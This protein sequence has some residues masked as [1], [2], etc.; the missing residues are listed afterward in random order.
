ML[1]H[2][3]NPAIIAHRGAS[4][5]APENTLAAFELAVR[6]KADA[7]ELDAKL[8]I[9][10]Y[11]VVFHDQTLDRTTG[12]QGRVIDSKLAELRRL[13]AGSHF[14]VAYKGEQIPTLDEVFDL[15]GKRIFINVELTNYA[16][17]LDRLPE[18]VAEI[19]NKH[20]L[21]ERVMFSSFN[22]IALIRVRRILP[23]VPIGL[24]ARPGRQG[25]WARSWIGTLIRYQSLNPALVDA[26]KRLFARTHRRGCTLLVYTVNQPEEMRRMFQL[27]VDGI[28]TYDPLTARRI[29][30]A[31]SEQ[32]MRDRQR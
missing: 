21:A 8:T 10:G 15:V 23:E 27:G 11:V 5:Y 22:P 14:D 31:V 30:S 20:S 25:A 32:R 12:A 24:L 6:Q 19:V 13:D 28:F 2:I 18:K 16:S 4:A 1:N 29:L 26:D 9:D 17:L 3:P 7:I